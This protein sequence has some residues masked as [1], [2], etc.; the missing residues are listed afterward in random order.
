MIPISLLVLLYNVLW[1]GPAK[2]TLCK[3][4]ANTSDQC[5]FQVL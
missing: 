2:F 1:L 3:A 5:I 4:I